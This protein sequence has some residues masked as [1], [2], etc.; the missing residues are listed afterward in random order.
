MH[1]VLPVLSLWH[2]HPLLV[3]LHPLLEGLLLLD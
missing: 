3:P 2:L 1:L